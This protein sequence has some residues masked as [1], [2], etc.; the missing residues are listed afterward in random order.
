MMSSR[1]LILS[2]G[3]CL[4]PLFGTPTVAEAEEKTAPPDAVNV[5]VGD[6]AEVELV[7]IPAGRFRMGSPQ[8]ERSRY[9]DEGPV[10]QV[11]IGYDFYIGKFEVTQRQWSAVMGNVP[12]R[13]SVRGDDYPV[14]TVS[15][16]DCQEFVQKLNGNLDI[17]GRFRLPTEAEWE[18]A[19]R[20]GTTTRFY[21]GDSLEGNDRLD[22]SPAGTLSGK[23]SDYIVYKGNPKSGEYRS[24]QE[25]AGSKK[26]NGFGLYNMHGSVKEWCEDEYHPNY[27]GAPT[28][29]SA[30]EGSRHPGAIRV[31]K[32]G[33]WSYYARTCRSAVRSGW[34][35]RRYW[36]NGLRL[37]WFPYKRTDEE[38]N[39]TWEAERLADNM[40][41]H[42]SAEGG[43]PKNR[44][45]H[46]NAY[47][48]EK[49][50]NSW[51]GAFDNDATVQEMRFL[52]KVYEATGKKRFKDSF[53]KGLD[54][55]FSAQYPTGGWPQRFPLGNNYG[56]YI[57]YNDNAMGNIMGLLKEI[58]TSPTSFAVIDAGRREQA[59]R[60]YDAGLDCILK[61][62]VVVDGRRTLW[63]AQHD[64]V[65]L[66]IKAAR[67]W[68]PA[69]L[70]SR[71]SA[72]LVRHFLMAIEN[73]SSEV[74][75]AIEG[76]VEFYRNH[77][78][79]F[80]WE[81]GDTV[82]DPTAKPL[83]A[84]FYEPDTGR[85]VFSTGHSFGE[86]QQMNTFNDMPRDQRGGYGWFHNEGRRVFEV[87][88]KWKKARGG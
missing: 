22:D 2:T 20:A 64:P 85:P 52:A 46:L 74:V 25:S 13:F 53:L 49:F 39:A 28:D 24:E 26:P 7:H 66:E 61:C 23:R 41:S 37:V 62:Q 82:D 78:L 47:Q 69:A 83:W 43:W 59:K 1:W 34:R 86:I 5:P 54:F 42:Q 9:S 75:E 14:T 40:I 67:R 21:F 80:R 55:I 30:W 79:H 63:G 58:V 31:L 76:A 8:S 50:A 87:Y 16:E 10:H 6:G 84:R 88:E 68:E 44:N 35:A 57:T 17:P 81:N 4:L 56:D 29:G 19:C 12:N 48:G 60:A 51:E 45:Y 73:P 18:Y 11:T 65:T 36:H 72:R 70:G 77:P 38:W 3:V 15:W 71:A 27:F 32:G 33:A